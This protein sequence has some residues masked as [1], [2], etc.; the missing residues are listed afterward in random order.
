MFST[1]VKFQDRYFI[2]LFFL[3]IRS[4]AIVFLF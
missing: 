4:S 1:E 2:F 3:L